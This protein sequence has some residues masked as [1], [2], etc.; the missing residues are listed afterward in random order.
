MELDYFNNYI[1]KKNHNYDFK[2]VL[3]E[4]EVSTGKPKPC[5]NNTEI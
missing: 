5:S 4:I 3:T 1:F 2:I